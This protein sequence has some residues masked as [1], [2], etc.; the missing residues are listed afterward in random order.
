MRACVCLLSG[1]TYDRRHIVH[2]LH[3]HKS[4]PLTGLAM[5]SK[6]LVPNLVLRSGVAEWRVKRGEAT[7]SS[8]SGSS[9]E[10]GDFAEHQGRG[11]EERGVNVK[12]GVKASKHRRAAKK[13][14]GQK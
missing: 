8:G 4:D 12:G 3:T 9:S 14:M 5:D 11:K 13:K 6:K 7:A 1:N 10:D 2:W